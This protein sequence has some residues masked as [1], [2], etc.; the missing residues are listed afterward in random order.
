MRG[1]YPRH[2]MRKKQMCLQTH[3]HT[4][5]F[6]AA[7]LQAV[8]VWSSARHANFVA[9]TREQTKPGAS[10]QYTG[11]ISRFGTDIGYVQSGVIL[12]SVYAPEADST[13]PPA[14]R[15]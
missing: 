1:C 5:A 6:S 14:L 3:S 10:E 7:M 8:G 15:R 2:R 12:W 4:S 13:S 11:S 9:L